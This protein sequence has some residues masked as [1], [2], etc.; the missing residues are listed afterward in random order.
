VDEISQ[1][2]AAEVAASGAAGDILSYFFRPDGSIYHFGHA[3]RQVAFDLRRL[4]RIR[5][6]IC[7]AGGPKKVDGILAAARL[8]YFNTLITDSVTAKAFYDK[9]RNGSVNR[10]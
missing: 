4:Q 7:L 1:R 9:F 2:C 5:K 8:G 3:Y 6:V 10:I